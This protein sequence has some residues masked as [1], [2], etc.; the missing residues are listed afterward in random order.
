MVPVSTWR[1]R[2]AVPDDRA[3]IVFSAL[4]DATRR[5]VVRHLA[6]QGPTTATQLAGEFPVTRQA[7]VKHLGALA[8]AGLV[9]RERQGREMRYRLTPAPFNDAMNWMA[10][11]GAEW[12]DRLS[13]LRRHLTA[14]PAAS[15]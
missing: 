2:P 14:K 15:R 13:S 8:D 9:A 12:D 3:G 10:S 11:V 4:A 6:E 1:P 5:E 7:L